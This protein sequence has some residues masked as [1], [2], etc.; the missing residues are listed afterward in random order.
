MT[1]M[2]E[3]SFLIDTLNLRLPA[4]YRHRAEFIARQVGRELSR[5]PVQQ[6]VQLPVLNLPGV[7]IYGGESDRVIAGRI[8]M[9]IHQQ[10][11]AA[12]QAPRRP[13]AGADTGRPGNSAKTG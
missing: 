6:D 13:Q 10:V 1:T 2:D 7:R 5:L 12:R 3:P 11:A 9:A 4:G 8:A